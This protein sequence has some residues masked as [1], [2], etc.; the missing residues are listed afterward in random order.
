MKRLARLI[1]SLELAE[2]ANRL[3]LARGVMFSEA[4]SAARFALIARAF[5]AIASVEERLAEASGECGLVKSKHEVCNIS[6]DLVVA[7]VTGSMIYCEGMVNARG[8]A[9]ERAIY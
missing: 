3:D 1:P 8:N 4:S 5:A 9:W 7:Y 6:E 2:C